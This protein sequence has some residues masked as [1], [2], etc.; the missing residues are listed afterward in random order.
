MTKLFLKLVLATVL[1]APLVGFAGNQNGLARPSMAMQ[2]DDVVE[3]T[4][5]V[6]GEQMTPLTLLEPPA[7]E[8]DSLESPSGML[9]DS[10]AATGLATAALD[11]PRPHPVEPR[12]R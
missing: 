10:V 9:Q 11:N 6:R 8:W 2:A 5:A 3:A 12:S 4:R 7:P 1:S